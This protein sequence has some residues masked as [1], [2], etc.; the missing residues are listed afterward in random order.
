MVG[1]R[2]AGSVSPLFLGVVAAVVAL[3]VLVFYSKEGPGE[4]ASRFMDGLARGDVNALVDSSY[5]P[6]KPPEEL[7]ED[8][9][10]TTNV[11]K[12]YLFRWRI[13]ATNV[14]DDDDATVK[15]SVEKNIGSGSSYEENFGLPMHK[16]GGKWMVDASG[17]SREMYPGLPRAGKG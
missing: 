10:F 8:W 16:V 4:A 7:R 3:F 13:T 12:H 6:G 17:I 14:V 9:K 5:A 2:R 11:G 1:M 15:L